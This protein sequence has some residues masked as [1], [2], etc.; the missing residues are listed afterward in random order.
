MGGDFNAD[1]LQSFDFLSSSSRTPFNNSASVSH[2]FTGWSG[3]TS[4]KGDN[5]FGKM[6]SDEFSSF[7]FVGTTDFTNQNNFICVGI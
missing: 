5:G 3:L 2:A 4:D 7:L 1:I 6:V